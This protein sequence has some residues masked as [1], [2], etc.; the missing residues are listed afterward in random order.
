MFSVVGKLVFITTLGTIFLIYFGHPSYLKYKKNQTLISETKVDFNRN[1]PPA[2]TVLAWRKQK[3]VGWKEKSNLTENCDVSQDFKDIIE[4]IDNKTFNLSEILEQATSGDESKTDITNASFWTE[5]LSNFQAGRCY[6]LNQS[7]DIGTDS[8]IFSLSLRKSQNYTI[9]IHD[10]NYFM[11]THN[12]DTVPRIQL[13]MD[14]SMTQLVYIKAIYHQMM[15]K[16]EHPCESSESYSF[17]ACIKNSISRKIGCRLEWDSW[18][19]RDI[20]VCARVDQLL[21][22]EEKYEEIDTWQQGSIVQYT[23]CLPPCS[24]TEY[25]LVDQPREFKPGHSLLLQLA[26]SKV[27]KRTEEIIYSMES[28]V[29]EFGGALGLFLGF[30]FMMVWDA[31]AFVVY[32]LNS[33]VKSYMEYN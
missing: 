4:C 29:S 14:R 3:E 24:Y 23:E 11:F 17:T 8:K 21:Q 33:K 2:I 15:D 1:K 28:F 13:I 31:L 25:K 19:S 22:F 9:F 5:D 26:S 18:S 16:P 12:P 20:P 7:Y 6:S 10:T 30:S 32:F 27:L